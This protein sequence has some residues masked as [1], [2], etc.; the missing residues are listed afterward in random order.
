MPTMNTEKGDPLANSYVTLLE[1]DQYF[2]NY[3]NTDDWMSLT[4]DDKM[5]YLITGS[6]RID[7]LPVQY[8]K[9]STTQGLKFPINNTSDPN[10]DGYDNA[11]RAT[12]VQALYLVKFNDDIEESI[13]DNIQGIKTSNLGKIQKTR[14]KAASNAF[15]SYDPKVFQ[16]LAPYIKF[17]TSLYRA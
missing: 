9:K 12:L 17:D 15:Y 8:S 4:N 1:A 7:E 3:I 2:D 11:K 16:I 6:R 13:S 10:D 5:R 14:Y